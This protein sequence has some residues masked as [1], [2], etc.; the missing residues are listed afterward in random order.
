M[1]NN[2][3]H[4]WL[5]GQNGPDFGRYL[6]VEGRWYDRDISQQGDQIVDM[7]RRHDDGQLRLD[8]LEARVVLAEKKHSKAV[9]RL[10]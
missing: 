9:S 6:H 5:C 10:R 7:R 8:E 1:S 3:H 2:A 4:G